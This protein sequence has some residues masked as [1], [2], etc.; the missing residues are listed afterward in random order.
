[1]VKLSVIS[2]SVMTAPTL[3]DDIKQWLGVQSKQNR[4]QDRTLR[5]PI[6]KLLLRRDPT[7][8]A[9]RLKSVDKFD[10]NHSKALPDM[11]KMSRKR[12]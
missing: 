1:M 11:S 4:A 12:E 6:M 8:D 7:V 5:N 3:G 2:K 10:E 9:D